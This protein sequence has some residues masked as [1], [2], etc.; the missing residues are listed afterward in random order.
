[1]ELPPGR[2]R[3]GGAPNQIEV[4]QRR[5]HL[6]VL[7]AVAVFV[8]AA[9]VVSK[10]LVVAKLADHPPVRLLDGLLTLD[11]TRNAGAAFSIG[12]GATYVF[13]VVAIAV[14]VVILRTARRLFSTP[15]AVVLGLLLGGATGNLVD[16]L[17]RSPG[18]LRGH[19]VD[20]IQLPHFAVFNLAD[21]AISIGGVL[22]VL[23]ALAGRQLDGTVARS[24]R[25]HPS[26]PAVASASPDETDS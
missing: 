7:F 23:L 14:I 3:A 8:L 24:A 2:H 5:R 17:L 20:W 1:M 18:V 19:V 12:T 11:Y 25:R 4:P 15:W 16:R 13:G 10:V 6:G 21:S 26:A 22:A 9:D